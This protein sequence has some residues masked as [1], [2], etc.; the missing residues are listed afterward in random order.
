MGQSNF[1]LAHKFTSYWEGGL[2]DHPADKGGVT[3]Y[4]A[5]LEF[6]KDIASTAS[7]RNFLQSI[8]VQ[9]PVTRATILALNRDQVATMFRREFWDKLGL[10]RFAF[11]QALLLYDAAVSHGPKRAVIL[12]QRGY[13]KI[14]GYGVPLIVDGVIG[15][16][17]IAALNQ[18]TDALV[19]AIVQARRDYYDAIVAS[20]PGQRAFYKG[21]INRSD[22]LE[23]RALGGD[24]GL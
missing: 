3:A 6:V 21:W 17:T 20:N 14:V 7:G 9:L 24:N 13:K 2:S 18:D 15:P 8:Q 11:R 22:A 5:S 12:S 16:K 10:D 19:K 1:A 4:G 23:R